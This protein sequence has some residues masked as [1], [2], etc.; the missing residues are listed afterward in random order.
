MWRIQRAIDRCSTITGCR[1]ICD[2]VNF[3]VSKIFETPKLVLKGNTNH[4]THVWC[5]A[6]EAQ[7]IPGTEKEHLHHRTIDGNPHLS[8]EPTHVE[9]NIWWKDSSLLPT[10][11]NELNRK[12]IK[13]D[14]NT[15]DEQYAKKLSS[16]RDQQLYKEGSPV[17]Y[18]LNI[19]VKDQHG[20][21][22]FTRQNLLDQEQ[23]DVY[24]DTFNYHNSKPV[25]SGSKYF[26]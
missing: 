21:K 17:N 11:I 4:H 23:Y 9:A 6:C 18:A 24:T 5:K 8:M 13:V 22:R 10:Q 20:R 2:F 19:E 14:Y 7:I 12:Y 1:D 26:Y 3:G 25:S 16:Y 15:D